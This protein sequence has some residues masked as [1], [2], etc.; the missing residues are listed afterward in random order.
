[1]RE[2]V[3]TKGTLVLFKAHAM[4]SIMGFY[5]F[6]GYYFIYFFH[7]VVGMDDGIGPHQDLDSLVIFTPPGAE[8][9]SGPPYG[10]YYYSIHLNTTK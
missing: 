1:M 3:A 2:L 9:Q 5:L 8:F 7:F 4:S 6:F 10:P